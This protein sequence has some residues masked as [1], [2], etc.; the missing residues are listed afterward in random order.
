LILGRAYERVAAKR[1]GDARDDFEEVAAQTVSFEAV[2]GAIDMRMTLGERPTSVDA[3]YD[4]RGVP[5]PLARFAKAYLIA[6]QLPK[7]EGEAHAN[8]AATALAA[9]DASWLDLKGE[10]PR[11][12]S[13]RRTPPRGLSGDRRPGGPRSGQHPLPGRA[14]ARGQQ[15]A[16]SRAHP[17][18]TGD[19]AHRRRRK[20]RIAL[21]YLLERDKL[22]YSDDSEGLDVLLSK[23]QA[24]LH[25]GRDVEAAKTGDAALAMIAR[26]PELTPYRLLA[27]DW[28][29]VDNLAAGHF[30]HAL[31]LYDREIPLLTASRS[32]S[33][34]RKSVW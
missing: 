30:E 18:S 32:L 20:L 8:A 7:L 33:N 1:Y 26:N 21:G 24:L 31:A 4:A 34:E 13:P 19:P 15:P 11:A 12:V 5:L 3:R 16:L 23:A 10:R 28:A 2:V 14:R 6:R 25:V 9:L 17:E 29:G 22:P 27:L